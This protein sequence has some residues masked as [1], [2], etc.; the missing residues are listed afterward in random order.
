MNKIKKRENLASLGVYAY[1][2]GAVAHLGAFSARIEFT[3][4]SRFCACAHS[5]SRFC[6]LLPLLI[7]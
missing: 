6:E 7:V 1:Q 2:E 5:D 3:P 4:V